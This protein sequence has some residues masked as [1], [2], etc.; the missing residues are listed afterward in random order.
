M[1]RRQ[2]DVLPMSLNPGDIGGIGDI[3]FPP[4]RDLWIRVP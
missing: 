4:V 2:R 1:T 3:Y